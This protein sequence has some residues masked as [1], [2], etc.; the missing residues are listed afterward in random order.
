MYP[1]KKKEKKLFKDAVKENINYFHKRF[2]QEAI[3]ILMPLLYFLYILISFNQAVLQKFLAFYQLHFKIKKKRKVA[4][5][6]LEEKE[7]ERQIDRH[8]HKTKKT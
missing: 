4:G 8:I 1:G 6:L 7:T 2:E 5:Y 3:F